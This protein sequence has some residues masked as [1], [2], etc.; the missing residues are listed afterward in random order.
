MGLIPGRWENPDKRRNP[1]MT[2]IARQ[3]RQLIDEM[4]IMRDDMR[5]MSAILMRLDGTIAGLVQEVRAMHGVTTA[6]RDGW[7]T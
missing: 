3:Q 6:S 1:D 7:T 2:L 5:V 4:G